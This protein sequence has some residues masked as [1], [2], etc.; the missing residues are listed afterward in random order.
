LR[1]FLMPS[2]AILILLDGCSAKAPEGVT[3]AEVRLPAAPGR[4]GAGYFTITGGQK[5]SQLM[6]ISSPKIVRIELHE[7]MTMGTMTQMKPLDG[8][9]AIPAGATVSF[10]PGGRHA[11]L[12]DINPR[13]KPGEKI[14]MTFTFADGRK[15]VSEA[16]V[17]APGDTAEHAH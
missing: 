2:L 15:I 12:F 5:D 6:A 11:M 13:V 16:V 14:P 7:S 17:K 3:N 10:A 8:G 9:I 1:H 4:P